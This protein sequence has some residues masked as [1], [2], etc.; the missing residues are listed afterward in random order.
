MHSAIY[1][2]SYLRLHHLIRHIFYSLSLILDSTSFKIGDN[3]IIG[4][5]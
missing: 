1:Y 2:K 3:A 5:I 4:L